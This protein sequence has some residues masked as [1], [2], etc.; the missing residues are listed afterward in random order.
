MAIGIGILPGHVILFHKITQIGDGIPFKVWRT[1]CCLNDTKD[2]V[3]GFFFLTK[4]ASLRILRFN[5]SGSIVMKLLK[6]STCYLEYSW[7]DI[8]PIVVVVCAVVVVVN[9]EVVG[10]WVVVGK[11]KICFKLVKNGILNIMYWNET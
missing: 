7:H 10:G 5:S 4:I 8:L 1:G 2:K 6:D 9:G 11:A 3:N